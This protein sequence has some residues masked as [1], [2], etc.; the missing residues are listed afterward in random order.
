MSRPIPFPP[1]SALGSLASVALSS[2]QVG[3]VVGGG[4]LVCHCS[5]GLQEK[6]YC[7]R[8]FLVWKWEGAYLFHYP[9]EG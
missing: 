1:E 3:V 9:T 2:A 6:N 7:K 4:W 8:L 5:A